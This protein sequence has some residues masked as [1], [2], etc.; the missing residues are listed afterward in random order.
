M[1]K[2]LSGSARIN[3]NIDPKV[4]ERTGFCVG[5]GTKD[6][7][8]EQEKNHER[9]NN[10]CILNYKYNKWWTVNSHICYLIHSPL[11]STI[12]VSNRCQLSN[13]AKRIYSQ[14]YKRLLTR[15][16][17]KILHNKN[18]YKIPINHNNNTTSLKLDISRGWFWH[19]YHSRGFF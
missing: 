17:S 10:K 2:I 18:T 3:F 12:P 11:I 1:N 6:E 19:Y 8:Q 15:F 5:G 16:I 4:V 9:C 14:F 7:R 13:L